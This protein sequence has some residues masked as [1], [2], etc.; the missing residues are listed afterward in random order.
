MVWALW[1]D[2]KYPIVMSC[3]FV[4]INLL[5]G[6]SPVLA[7]CWHERCFSITNRFPTTED[8][9]VNRFLLAAA[10]TATTAL[11]APAYAVTTFSDLSAWQA[12]VTSFVEDRSEER[13]VGKEC[14]STC[15]SRWST[16]H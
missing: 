8:K 1:G 16:Y 12:S 13:R 5:P 11:S 9:A 15:R 14:V 3:F 4:K 7:V 6:V 10:L 2:L